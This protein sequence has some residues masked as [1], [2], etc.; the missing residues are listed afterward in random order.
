MGQVADCLMI[1][2]KKLLKLAAHRRFKDSLWMERYSY[3]LSK[4]SYVMFIM[5]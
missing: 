1:I 4:A 2:F 5:K 3:V